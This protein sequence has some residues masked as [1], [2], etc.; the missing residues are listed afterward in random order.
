MAGLV[1]ASQAIKSL[2][3][4]IESAHGGHDAAWESFK[5]ES[6]SY[7]TLN[8]HE[9]EATQKLKRVWDENGIS[10]SR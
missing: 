7:S 2:D 4:R 8:M 10:S 9:D 1:P 5:P 6:V 3:A